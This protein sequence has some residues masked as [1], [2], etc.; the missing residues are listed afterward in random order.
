MKYNFLI[1]IFL[2]LL[3][4]FGFVQGIDTC[5][6][7]Y[8]R[9]SCVNWSVG[10]ITNHSDLNELDYASSGHTG[11]QATITNLAVNV[12]G[13]GTTSWT[14][15][16][17]PYLSTTTAFSEIAI[18]TDGQCLK[19]NST[20]NGYEWGACTGGSET[21]PHWTTN[22][23][24]YNDTWVSTY[25]ATYDAY[26]S[27]GLIRDWNATDY[28]IDWN[29][30]A[31]IINWSTASETDPIW[32]ANYS[33]YLN[34]KTY[35][36][37][38]TD[39]NAS[40]HIIDWNATNWIIDWNATALIINWSKII[41]PITWVEVINGT[42]ISQDTFNTNYTANDLLYR[43]F[44]SNYSVFLTHITWE[45]VTN[46]TMASQSIVNTNVTTDDLHTHN[47][48]NITAGTFGTGNY[49]FDSNITS[50]CILFSTGGKICG[51]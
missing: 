51:I 10:N 36:S 1:L 19:V 48:S 38:D 20:A 7:P 12:G 15:F 45:N 21:D 46:G 5:A 27:S 32:S 9:I 26:N 23:T 13:T 44:A 40:G 39:F 22:A 24:A 49:I 35:A 43:S 37:N 31:L 2:G 4:S 8:V 18:G 17:L 6:N 3:L 11:F 30:T 42:M 33:D 28:I 34:T 29:A 47:A 50:D 16:A 41:I 25:N 14:Q